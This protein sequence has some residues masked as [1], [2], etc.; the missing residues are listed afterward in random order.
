MKNPLCNIC[1]KN[2]DW[3]CIFSY[4]EKQYGVSR[5]HDCK[6]ATETSLHNKKPYNSIPLWFGSWAMSPVT[7]FTPLRISR[8]EV[9]A[10]SKAIP[11]KNVFEESDE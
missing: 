9:E 2:A 11:L 8:D 1:G 7:S 6:N 10:R 3:Y 5:C 4:K